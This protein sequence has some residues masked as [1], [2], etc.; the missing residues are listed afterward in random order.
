VNA[1]PSLTDVRR[2]VDVLR[3]RG[4][5]EVIEDARAATAAGRLTDAHAAYERAL[6]ASPESAFLYREIGVVERTQG[7]GQ[8]ALGRFRRAADLDP[9]DSA[10]LIQI[11][12]ILEQQRDFAGAEAAYRKAA[13]I[14]PSADLDRRIATIA[15]SA[16]DA[17]LPGEFRAIGTASV[18]TRGDLAA[19]IGVRLDAVLRSAPANEVVVTD[20]NSHWASSWITEAARAGV[21]EPYENHTFQPQ[22]IVTRGDLA[23]AVSRLVSLLAVSRTDLRKYVTEQ[24]RIADMA[25]THLSYPAAAV[26][27]ASGVMPLVDGGRF[28]VA[29]Q[30]TGADATQAIER[31]QALMAPPPR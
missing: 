27:V 16:R 11:G 20:I 14:E 21:I 24:P 7:N 10:S 8:A 23:A 12:E 13:D 17:R 9:G 6:A 29:R 22:Q 18:V 25:P 1:D 31:V 3:F 2:R 26:A 15:A 5:Q 19:L 30:V 4:L 28:D